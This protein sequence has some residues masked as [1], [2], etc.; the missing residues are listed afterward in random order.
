MEYFRWKLTG[1]FHTIYIEEAAFLAHG[2]SFFGHPHSTLSSLRTNHVCSC[3]D[4]HVFLGIDI[5]G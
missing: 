4:V 1:L 2:N 5:A 3:G